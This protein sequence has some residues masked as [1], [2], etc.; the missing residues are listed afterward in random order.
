MSADRELRDRHGPV[1]GSPDG[2]AGQVG[3]MLRTSVN[4]C[5]RPRTAT[6]LDLATSIGATQDSYDDPSLVRHVPAVGNR[7]WPGC[8]PSGRSAEIGPAPAAWWSGMVVSLAA[9][10][11]VSSRRFSRYTVC[12]RQASHTS[13]PGQVTVRAGGLSV[14]LSVLVDQGCRVAAAPAV[15]DS[16]GDSRA[17][18]PPQAP[19]PPPQASPGPPQRPG[20]AATLFHPY[21]LRADRGQV[22]GSRCRAAGRH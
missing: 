3:T 15:Q 16:L 21:R 9:S 4:R 18:Q 2:I 11:Q 13:E 22:T 7:R 1:Q 14:L 6:S 19:Q 10:S 8:L 12:L 20:D 17:L 5:G